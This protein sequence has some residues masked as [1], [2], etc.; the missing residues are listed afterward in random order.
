M[1]PIE[2]ISFAMIIGR[3]IIVFCFSSILNGR[4][5]SE[6]KVSSHSIIWLPSQELY[7]SIAIQCPPLNRIPLS[8]H[9]SDNV[10]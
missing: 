5:Q 3:D 4:N 2:M 1:K 9:K 7:F 8:R 6:K 10:D